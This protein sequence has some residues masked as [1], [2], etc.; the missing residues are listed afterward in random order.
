MAHVFVHDCS[1]G[2]TSR[3]SVRSGGAQSITGEARGPALNTDGRFVAFS[4]MALDSVA[5]DT[6]GVEDVFVHDRVNGQT[7]RVQRS[8]S[9]GAEGYSQSNDPA[10]DGSGRLI[11][12]GSSA[13]TL[14]PAD[15]NAQ[16]DVFLHDRETGVTSRVNLGPGDVESQPGPIGAFSGMADISADGMF[17]GFYSYAV[18]LSG[19]KL[20]GN[21]H[22]YVRDLQAGVTARMDVSFDGAPSTCCNSF[23]PALSATGRFVAFDSSFTNV[24]P[25]TRTRSTTCS[26]ATSTWTQTVC[27]PRGRPCSAWTDSSGPGTTAGR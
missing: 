11:V 13:S 9:S 1:T 5:G 18:N 6:N 27:S 22:V 16:H 12:F 17:V 21:P 3:V 2:V 23:N 20:Q 24:V 4:S 8:L 7:E 26:Y 10:I 25:G 14:V 15:R 19:E